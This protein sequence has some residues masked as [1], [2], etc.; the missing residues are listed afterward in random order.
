[1]TAPDA[2]SRREQDE[3]LAENLRDHGR[4]ITDLKQERDKLEARTDLTTLARDDRTSREDRR[5]DDRT[6]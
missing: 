6:P 1:M 5:G 2:T 4:E 3:L